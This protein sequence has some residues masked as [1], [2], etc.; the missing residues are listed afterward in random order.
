MRN[1][2]NCSDLCLMNN[3]EI[4][5]DNLGKPKHDKFLKYISFFGFGLSK[6][7]VVRALSPASPLRLF[8][9]S[10]LF[11]HFAPSLRSL[12]SLRPLR[13]LQSLKSLRLSVCP[14]SQA[15]S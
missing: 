6:L 5:P 10:L 1:I 4:L 8:H 7:G 11:P 3:I 13:S 2:K 14:S 15:S 9:L 12:R